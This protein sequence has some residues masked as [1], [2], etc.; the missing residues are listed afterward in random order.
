[1]RVNGRNRSR[2]EAEVCFSDRTGRL[3]PFNREAYPENQG[4]P[5]LCLQGA[6][7]DVRAYFAEEDGT[8]PH[9]L[10]PRRAVVLDRVTPPR[11]AS[12]HPGAAGRGANASMTKRMLIDDASGHNDIWTDSLTG[13]VVRFVATLNP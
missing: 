7:P 1:M 12:P 6:T 10:C 11:S 13:E 5:T 2:Q 4:V 3:T 9:A 8:P